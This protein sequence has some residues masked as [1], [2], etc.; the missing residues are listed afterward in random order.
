MADT[1][2]SDSDCERIFS[3]VGKSL[4]EFRANMSIDTQD[5]LLLRKVATYGNSC[6][7]QQYDDELLKK[8][9]SA[10]YAANS[11]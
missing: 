6:F 4:N 11:K 1:S 7:N 2:D 9:K 3:V 8:A 5:K 10:T